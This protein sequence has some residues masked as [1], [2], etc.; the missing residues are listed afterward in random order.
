MPDIIPSSWFTLSPTEM[1]RPD[2]LKVTIP[3]PKIWPLALRGE[4]PFV[5]EV[6]SHTPTAFKRHQHPLRSTS[7]ADALAEADTRFPVPEWF[8]VTEHAGAG[9]LTAT[10]PNPGWTCN[11]V[12]NLSDIARYSEEDG[13]FV[14]GDVL[15]HDAFKRERNRIDVHM[16]RIKRLKPRRK[17]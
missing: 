15:D 11:P 1:Q 3:D 12:V 4:C 17:D 13:M 8:T 9:P 5:A 16:K 10:S 2:G 14:G 6:V 7:L